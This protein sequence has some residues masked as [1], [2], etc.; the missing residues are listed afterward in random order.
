MEITCKQMTL[1]PW[2]KTFDLQIT[3]VITTELNLNSLH[4]VK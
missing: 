4:K 1:T 3:L 2:A